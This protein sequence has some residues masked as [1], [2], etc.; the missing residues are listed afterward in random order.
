MSSLWQSEKMQASDSTATLQSQN[1]ESPVPAPTAASPTL[2]VASS[3]PVPPVGEPVN[4]AT[5][6]VSS[7]PTTNANAG[8]TVPTVLPG[9][10]APSE[11]TPVALHN[12]PNE[13]TRDPVQAKFVSP[14]GYVVPAPSFSYNL[15]PR[16][17]SSAGSPQQSAMKLIPPMPAAAL[18]PP[19]PGQ[20]FGNSPSF[21][22][23]VFPHANTITASGQQ[24]RP[25]TATSQLQL[26]GV[27]LT[28]ASLQPPVPGQ[29]MRLNP[30]FPRTFP[31][32]IPR[33]AGQLSASSNFSFGES[34]HQ[35]MTDASDKSLNPND[36]TSNVAVPEA[37]ISSAEPISS[38]SVKTSS[39]IPASS[40][41]DSTPLSVQ[42]SSN[43]FAPTSASFMPRPGMSMSGS[44]ADSSPS[45]LRPVVPFPAAPSNLA[46]IAMAPT[47]N[48]QQQTHSH[49]PLMSA[50]API[51]QSPW[52]H[53]P[54]T[55]G[56]PHAPFFPHAG[57]N[58]SPFP[59]P[60]RG[61]SVTS[62]PSPGVQPPGVSTAMHSDVLTSAES[63]P[64]S[65]VIVGPLPPGIDRDKEANDLHKDGE[66]T[67]REEV[68]AWTAHKTE[69]GTIYYYN[70]ITGESTYNKP[71]SFKGE[72][73]KVANQSTPVTWEKIAGTNWTLVTTNDG[74][75]Y[76]YD[77]MNKVSSWQ[78]P[79]E[80]SEMK[81]NQESD[82]SKGNMVQ[83]ENTN[84]VAEKVSAPIYISTP[85][86]HTGGRDSMVVRP[87]GGQ[88]SSSALDL[89]KKK[90]QEAGSPVTSTPLSPSAISTT[91]LNGSRAADAVAKG[92]QSMNS[93]DK[94]KDANGE[95]NM[96]DSSSDSDDAESGPTKEECII[97][98]RE[99]LKKRGVAPFSKWDK[100]LPKIVFDPRFKAVP[101]HS[102]RRS[103]FEHFVRTR[104]EE[105]RKEKR[106]AQKAAIDGFKQLLE[107]VSEDIDHKT[108]YQTFKKKWGT[109]PRFEAL[110]RKERM[111]L[112]NEKVLP[113]KKAADE[114]NLAART[115]AFKSFKSMLR[116]NKDITI[117][118]RWSKVKDGLKSDP[119]YKSVKHEEREILFNEYLSELKAAED[120]AERT[121]KTKRD[122]HDK[123][124]EREREMRKRKE[125]EEQ[126]ME[127]IRVK[128]RR[129]EAISSYQALLVETIKDPK[130]S[131]TESKPKLEKDPQGR[132]ANPDLSEA[133]M[134]KLFRD[135]VK[136]LLERCA[137]EYRFLLAEVIT[138]EAAAKVSDDGKNVLNS[139]TE[140][141]R[142]L[143]P[144]ARYSKMPRKER[145]SLWI[146]YSD[147]MIRKHKPAADP[148]D[149][150]D[151]GGKDKSSADI[152]RKSP[153]RSHGRR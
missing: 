63:N 137:R 1:S 67:K 111:L 101:S 82:A 127:R 65:K 125:R 88:V 41:T 93:K 106:A 133:D 123:L 86:M 42:S 17:N 143:K 147:D 28:A 46:S 97:Q 55:G 146:R 3:S 153:R 62:V 22:Y 68:D 109:D 6:P 40:S 113:L 31:Q 107:E 151:R 52:L 115:A 140:A 149:K 12:S 36:G 135:H 136:D 116:E 102:A 121:A 49:Y 124:K 47:R 4:G 120:E 18:Q 100:E 148:K 105:E 24:F 16:V 110:D 92:Q 132:A 15:F 114:K 34:V 2:A 20:S 61:V 21:S 74:K 45:P 59:L 5:T 87:S 60:I 70:S 128:V 35:S 104:A 32:N 66:T 48:V 117:G 50:M 141:K 129:K 71:S 19:V 30:T 81:K 142:L 131:W 150:S 145:E 130:A 112:L 134:E 26:Q 38:K 76:Y 64:M 103:I 53:P 84:I 7:T 27:K 8:S 139:W 57:A 78:I 118:S 72:L 89:I 77:T 80:V 29:P 75:K 79:S 144:D 95:A 108:D 91:E 138:M 11:T 25:V 9:S 152:S 13:P 56:L 98:F 99:M 58:P 122:E 69:S 85:A 73:E 54:L 51:A 126:E 96:S 119:R 39:A 90:L 33:P 14:A 23:N 37:G 94:A 44:A 43:I 10:S 83:D